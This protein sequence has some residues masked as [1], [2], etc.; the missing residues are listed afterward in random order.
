MS[1]LTDFEKYVIEQKGTEAPFSGE[2]TNL[3]SEG[4]YLCK[5]CRAPLYRSEHKF[6]SHCG[7]PSFD[8]EIQGAVTRHMDADGK[9]TE[10]VCSKCGGHLGHVFEGEYL[11]EK[12]V[13]H[14]V[15]SVSMIFEATEEVKKTKFLATFGGGCFWCIEAVFSELNGVLNVTSGYSGGLATEAN[16]KAVCSGSTG[17]AEVVQIEFDPDV[18]DYETLML[19]FF[20]AH[21]PTTYNQQ[22]ND[23]GPQYR[24]V[25]FA[26]NSLQA[27]KA[28]EFIK[29]LELSCVFQAPIVTELTMLESFYPAENYHNDYYELHGHQP[30]CQI[31]IKPKVDKI[32]KV[33]SDRIKSKNI[34]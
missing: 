22:G 17:H 9:R 14:C 6:I 34:S 4:I 21:D 1:K 3:D 28:S 26:H 7:W 24:S 10:I 2:Y 25:I 11:T 15:N 27:E 8:D 33:F 13:R 20:E 18:I 19:V 12:N 5:K 31:V 23:I 29:H 16:Y 30:Y 32:R